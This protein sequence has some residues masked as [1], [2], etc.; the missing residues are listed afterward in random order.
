VEIVVC[1]V[2]VV[3]KPVFVEETKHHQMEV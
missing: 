2:T 1:I 3:I